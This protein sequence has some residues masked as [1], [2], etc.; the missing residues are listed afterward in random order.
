MLD[1]SNTFD[2]TNALSGMFLWIIFGY[3]SALL[4]CDLQRFLQQHPIFIHLMGITAFFFLFTIIDSSNKTSI[5]HIWLKTFF[6]YV[7]FVLMTKSKWFFVIPVLVLLLID[8]SIK[9]D[10]SLKALGDQVISKEEADKKLAISKKINIIVISLIL[11]G[12]VHYAY[13]QY[14]EYKGK[15]SWYLFFFGVTKCKKKSPW[16]LK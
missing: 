2:S 16:I 4:N 14:K 12:V 8:Q 13:I 3:L 9:K 15:F 6:I 5:S 7:L 1:F 10:M 11:I